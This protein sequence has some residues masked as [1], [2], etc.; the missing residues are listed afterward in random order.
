MAMWLCGYVAVWLSFK[1]FKFQIPNCQLF[2]FQTS[3]FKNSQ[4][5]F[6]MFKFSNFSNLQ[7]SIYQPLGAT[8]HT[9]KFKTSYC[10]IFNFWISKNQN[11]QFRNFKKFGTYI[12]KTFKRTRFPY[13]IIFSK[14]VHM[15]SSF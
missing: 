12:S 3:N 4:S 5:P 6:P 7:I 14:G 1:L 2:S 10:P 11:M 15:F 13:K 8:F 9:S